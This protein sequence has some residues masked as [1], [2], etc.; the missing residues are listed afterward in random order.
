MSVARRMSGV[1]GG[2]ALG[3]GWGDPHPACAH[4]TVAMTSN[5]SRPS[6]LN[7][8]AK[9]RKLP[10]FRTPGDEWYKSAVPPPMSDSVAEGF[11]KQIWP[12]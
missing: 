6:L 9:K 10:P 4:A 12:R 8:V 3:K 2:Q 7:E 1:G 5:L 11:G